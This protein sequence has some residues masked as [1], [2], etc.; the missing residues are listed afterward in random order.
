MRAVVV[1]DP[2]KV[3]LSFMWLP[4]FI[5]QDPGLKKEIEKTIAQEFQGKHVDVFTLD[6]MHHRVLD[7]ICEKHKAIVGLRDYLDSLKFVEGPP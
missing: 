4:L 3:E 6:E 5:G 7:I 2:G 1:T